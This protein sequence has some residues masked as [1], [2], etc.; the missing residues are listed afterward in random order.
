MRIVKPILSTASMALILAACG[1]PKLVSTPI[2]NIDNTPLKVTELTDTEMKHWGHLDLVQDTIPG[3]SVEKAYNEILNA[4][5]GQPVI[6]GVIDSGVDINHE[7]LKDVIWINKDEVPNNGIDDDKNGYIDDVYGWNFLG[8]A[9]DE[10]LELTRIVKKGDDGSAAYQKAK[11]EFDKKKQEASQNAQRYEQIY[12]VVL[13]ADEAI[14]KHLGKKEYT[15]EDVDA[16]ETDDQA[17]LQAKGMM[18]QFLSRTDGVADLKEQIKGGVD[19]YTDQLKYNLNLDFDGRAVVGDDPYDINDT[20]YGN[21]DVITD[22]ELAKHG[23]HVAGIIA[24]TRNNNIGM[25]GVAQNVEIMA[26]RAVPN[27]DEYDKDIALAIRYA[28]DNGAKVINTSFGKYYSPNPEWV[29]DAIKYAAEKDVLIVNAAGNEGEDLDKTNV[30]P[31]DAKDN[32]P[33][34]ADNFLTV[35]ALHY[36]YGPEMIATFSNYGEVNVDVFAPGTKIWATT[37]ENTYEYLQG[38]SMAAPAVAGVAATIRSYY[39]K[40]SA[41]QVKQV[42]MN[43]GLAAKSNVILGGNP[44][45]K[46]SFATISKSGKMVNLYNAIILADKVSRGEINL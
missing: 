36:K 9:V 30:Y 23:T 40:L 38:T 8:E 15:K 22:S 11:A 17:L 43:S 5:K 19:Y 31:N 24:A 18:S 33:E 10:N 35:G 46:E 41:A 26:V 25:D 3:M 13:D 2:E 21:G 34:I 42:I 28:V 4:R 14:A 6:V 1:S 44:A 7:D 45:D 27:G 29:W 37:P 20:D 16:I 39:P 12:Q 32:S